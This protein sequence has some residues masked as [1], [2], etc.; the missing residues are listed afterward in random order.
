MCVI[1]IMNVSRAIE[2]TLYISQWPDFVI[3]LTVVTIILLRMCI[4]HTCMYAQIKN[5][6]FILTV[7]LAVN[8][9]C[10]YSTKE[11]K[12]YTTVIETLNYTQHSNNNTNVFHVYDV[13]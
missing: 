7:I 1:H 6:T 12:H 2:Q 8:T 13:Q 9:E 3:F 4:L 11:M 10:K 5:G